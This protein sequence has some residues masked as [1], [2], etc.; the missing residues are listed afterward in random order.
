MAVY[1][2]KKPLRDWLVSTEDAAKALHVPKATIQAICREGYFR[3]DSR[4]GFYR[5][6]SLLDGH[7]E[8]VRM[9][10]ISPPHSRGTDPA[11][12]RCVVAAL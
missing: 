9:G 10:R 7:A 12:M 11:N 8:A 4:K 5:L 1:Q 3:A 6:G 2:H